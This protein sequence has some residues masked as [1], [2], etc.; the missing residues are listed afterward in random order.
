MFIGE[1]G[2]FNR[3]RVSNRSRGLLLEE[4]RYINFS[5]L[6]GG[7]KASVANTPSRR[8]RYPYHAWLSYCLSRKRGHFFAYMQV[9]KNNQ[10]RVD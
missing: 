10:S 9:G 5:T 8:V 1:L 4:I 3:S 6:Y 7:T 2:G